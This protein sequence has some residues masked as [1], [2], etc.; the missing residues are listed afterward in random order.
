MKWCRPDADASPSPAGGASVKKE[1][2]GLRRASSVNPLSSAPL[3]VDSQF[4]S[5][6]SSGVFSVAMLSS[7]SIADCQRCWC[8]LL[9]LIVQ[10]PLSFLSC[11]SDDIVVSAI[12]PMLLGARLAS[13]LTFDG[14]IP[15][16]S[17][18]TEGFCVLTFFLVP[19]SLSF[20]FFLRC[21]RGSL[22]D[23]FFRWSGCLRFP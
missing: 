8:L 15:A 21:H 19:G 14:R 13:S 4:W 18:E 12:L 2:P 6:R 3:R 1:R 7:S 10:L 11:S 9:R 5:F 16:V 23:G 17:A 20:S 22:W